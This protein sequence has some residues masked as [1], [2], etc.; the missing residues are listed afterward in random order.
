METKHQDSVEYF[1]HLEAEM[2]KRIHSLMNCRSFTLAFGRAMEFHLKQV[3][4]HKRLTTRWLKELDLPNKDELAAISIRLVDCED[5]LDVLDETI[6]LIS[7]DQRANLEQLKI[8][9]QTSKELWVF[10]K[11]EAIDIHNGKLMTLE[12]ELLDLKKIFET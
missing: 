9:R 11:Q 2:N 6:Y 3:K 12:E 7:K 8:V 1:K 5:R 10:L 4:V